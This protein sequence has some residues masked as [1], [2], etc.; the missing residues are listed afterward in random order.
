MHHELWQLSATLT[1]LGTL[2]HAHC[3]VGQSLSHLHS[4]PLDALPG[5]PPALCFPCCTQWPAA[6][7][8]W[9]AHNLI[10]AITPHSQAVNAAALHGSQTIIRKRE[11]G[12]EKST[13]APSPGEGGEKWCRCVR[14]FSAPWG[15]EQMAS[16]GA[17]RRAWVLRT[18]KGPLRPTGVPVHSELGK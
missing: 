4:P 9:V 2:F 13:G 15:G 6:P 14:E 8:R 7:R 3:P 11:L 12:L 17:S 10:T 5:L 16:Y 18:T 1:A